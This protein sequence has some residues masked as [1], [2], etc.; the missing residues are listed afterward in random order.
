MQI[1]ALFEKSKSFRF[2][3]K[4]WFADF[5]KGKTWATCQK[6]CQEHYCYHRTV[7]LVKY[8]FHCKKYVICLSLFSGHI[9]LFYFPANNIYSLQKFILNVRQIYIV[10][11][12]NFKVSRLLRKVYTLNV[13][14]SQDLSK[15]QPSSCIVIQ[16]LCGACVVEILAR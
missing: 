14:G 6:R 9:C 4:M 12:F 3:A 13:L 5:V 1:D 10:L 11:L 2:V 8:C 15:P 16:N 7:A